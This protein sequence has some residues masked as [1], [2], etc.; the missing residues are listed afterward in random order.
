MAT[1]RNLE[2]RGRV[3]DAEQKAGIRDRLDLRR[4]DITEFD[5]LAGAVDGIVHDFDRI[6]VL[7]NNGRF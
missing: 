3:E 6:D 5:S 1:M 2:N 4:L 7:V